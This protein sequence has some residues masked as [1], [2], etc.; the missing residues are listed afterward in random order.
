M[1]RAL[2][3]RESEMMLHARRAQQARSMGRIYIPGYSPNKA[4]SQ[5]LY[6]KYVKHAAGVPREIEDAY[7]QFL[8]LLPISRFRPVT[9][10]GQ[11]LWQEHVNAMEAALFHKLTPEEALGRGTA[12][13]QREHRTSNIRTGQFLRCSMLDVRCS[14]FKYETEFDSQPPR[15]GNATRSASGT[16]TRARREMKAKD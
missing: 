16:A 7:K 15:R 5:V 1:I 10:V 3:S 11:R 8:A 6:E 14:M 13:V 9:P 2:V 4:T 12:I